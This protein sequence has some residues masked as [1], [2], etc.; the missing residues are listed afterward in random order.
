MHDE[1]YA[2]AQCCIRCGNEGNY[3]AHVRGKIHRKVMNQIAARQPPSTHVIEIIHCYGMDNIDIDIIFEQPSS[4][5][6]THRTPTTS[7]Q[8]STSR[9]PITTQHSSTSQ[10]TQWKSD[11]SW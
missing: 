9:P 8:P 6:N 5:Q 2:C 1:R 7:Q 3:E 11:A 4:H 10:P